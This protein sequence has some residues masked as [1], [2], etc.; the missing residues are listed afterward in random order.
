MGGYSF[1]FRGIMKKGVL[2]GHCAIFSANFVWGAMSPIV[3][4]IFACRLITPLVLVSFRVA[5]AAVLFWVLSFIIG[6]EHVKRRDKMLFFVAA[7]LG[8]VFN[9]GVYTVGLGLTSPVDA[10][11]ISTSTPIFTMIIAALYLREPMTVK[12]VSGVLL[13]AAGAVM[14]ILSGADGG[15]GGNVAGDLLCIFAELC[16]AS[17]LVF[18]KGLISRYSPL[19]VMKWMFTWSSVCVLPFTFRDVVA[20]DFGSLTIDVVMAIVFVIVFATFLCY[21][22]A[23]IGQKN[24]RPT[25]VSMYFYAQPVVS[26]ILATIMG[27]AGSFGPVKILSIIMIFVGVALV[28]RSK[29]RADI[30]ASDN[31]ATEPISQ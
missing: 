14:L 12:K 22:L 18:F 8:V 11:V 3:K 29:S 13:G 23:P 30:K 1:Y 24:L 21:M 19:T 9:Q 17:Y 10:S 26:A 7:I 28:M 20:V 6:G 5:G 4:Y 27:T 15:I 31:E 2:A 25:V 16:F